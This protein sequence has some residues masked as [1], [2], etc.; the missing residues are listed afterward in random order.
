MGASIAGYI[1]EQKDGLPMVMADKNTPTVKLYEGQREN[2][3]KHGQGSTMFANG[4]TYV[5]AHQIDKKYGFGI[6]KFATGDV[7]EGNF[8]D[9]QYEGHGVFKSVGG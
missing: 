5:S 7:Y 8:V 2:D 6:I 4:N 1:G 3:K 9:D